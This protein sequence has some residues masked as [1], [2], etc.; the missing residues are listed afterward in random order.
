MQCKNPVHIVLPSVGFDEP[1]A[2][3]CGKCRACRVARAREWAV[4]CVHEASR[5]EVS[6]FVTL[7]Y[8]DDCL[9]EN[10]SLRKVE[11]QK[12]MKRL[13]RRL[14]PRKIRYFGAGEYGDIGKRPHYHLILFGVSPYGE[15]EKVIEA[16]WSRGFV[17]TGTVTYDSARYTADYVQKKLYGDLARREYVGRE[18]PF[19]IQSLGLGRDWLEEN[20]GQVREYLKCTIRGVNVGLP[21]YYKKKLELSAEELR[22]AAVEGRQE[23]LDHYLDKYGELDA[24]RARMRHLEQFDRNLEAKASVRKQRT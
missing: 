20:Q 12:F 2:V 23:L 14:E 6:A 4:R 3:P 1:F 16:C 24:W 11:L 18:A 5:H 13:R 21:R 15:D 10:L 17:H 8:A 7:T 19:Q 22:E 9:P